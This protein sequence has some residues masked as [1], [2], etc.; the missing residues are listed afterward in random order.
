MLREQRYHSVG[1]PFSARNVKSTSRF[2]APP[3]AI[4]Q[5]ESVTLDN[6]VQDVQG[7]VHPQILHTTLAAMS[8]CHLAD[9]IFSQFLEST[10]ETS[11]H[12]TAFAYG[13]AVII[14]STYICDV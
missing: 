9:R 6:M 5:K 2:D 13:G 1:L 14:S 11:H 12:T 4:G 8:P 10:T 3:E 7:E